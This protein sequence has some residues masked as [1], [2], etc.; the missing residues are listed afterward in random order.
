MCGIAGFWYQN[1]KRCTGEMEEFARRMGSVLGH[2]GPDDSG[3]VVFEHDGLALAHRRLSIIDVSANGH[4][5]MTS[6]CGRIVIVYNGELYNT[7]ELRSDLE[8][9]GRKFRGSSDTE[10]SGLCCRAQLG[11]RW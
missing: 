1:A 7:A 5:P 3:I 8:A 4:Q 9:V 6:S 11:I 10:R 2:R